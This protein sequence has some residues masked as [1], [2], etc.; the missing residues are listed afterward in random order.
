[1]FGPVLEAALNDLEPRATIGH[2][3]PG[4]TEASYGHLFPD[5]GAKVAATLDA[6][7]VEGRP[8]S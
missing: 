8:C 7:L 6:Y 1:V 2:G 5:P 4:T 3:D